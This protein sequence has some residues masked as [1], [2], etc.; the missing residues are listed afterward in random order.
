MGSPAG[1]RD[2]R[3]KGEEGELCPEALW[4]RAGE[5]GLQK[6]KPGFQVDT[7]GRVRKAGTLDALA[8]QFRKIGIVSGD[9]GRRGRRECQR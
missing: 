7:G 1:V 2:E 4:V 5:L 8:I 6:R 9:R 3:R